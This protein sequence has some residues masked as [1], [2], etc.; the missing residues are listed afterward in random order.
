MNVCR[1]RVL[2][3]A[4]FLVVP[5][6]FLRAQDTLSVRAVQDTASST[7]TTTPAVTNSSTTSSTVSPAPKPRRVR[8]SPS[9]QNTTKTTSVKKEHSATKALLW[10]L[11]PGAGQVYNHQAWKIPIIYTAFAGAG[12]FIYTN[13][14]NMVKFKKEYLYRVNNGGAT[15]LAGYANYPTSNIYNL[16]Q[17]Y[18]QY[19]QLSIIVAAAFYGLNLIDAYVFGHLFDYDISDDISLRACPT[20]LTVPDYPLPSAPGLSLTL[21]F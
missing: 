18:N 17:S 1:A 6:L 21:T 10:S 2:L 9:I 14:T 7:T 8:T 5:A 19:F 3:L 11:I 12:Y 16:Y 20:M 13:G 4:L 15:Q